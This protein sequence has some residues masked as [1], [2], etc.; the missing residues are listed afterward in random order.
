MQ[1]LRD[2]GRAC[3][4]AIRRPRDTPIWKLEAALKCRS[5]KKGRYAPPVHMIK[6]TAT[7]ETRRI[8]G[9]IRTR[10]GGRRRREIRKIC[11]SFRR[12]FFLE[13][14]QP[15]GFANVQAVLGGGQIRGASMCD[16]SLHAFATRP[17]E[18]AETLV[19]TNFYT[20]TR[21]CEPG[22]SASR[23]LPSSRD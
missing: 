9:C 20:G 12:R 11:L 21:G 5:C 15:K 17:A 2:P 13:D 14:S 18:V 3:R 16:Y 10:S 1:S 6:L 8:S 22:Q 23:G 4:D 19:S 7:Q